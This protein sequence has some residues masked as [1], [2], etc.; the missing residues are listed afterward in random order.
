LN[1]GLDPSGNPLGYYQVIFDR[2]KNGVYYF[3]YADMAGQSQV[4]D[5]VRKDTTVNYLYYSFMFQK[6]QPLEPSKASWDLL[7]TQY[8]TMLFTDEGEPYPY[9]VTGVLSN[10]DGVEV[11]LDTTAD[12]SSVTSSGASEFTYSSALDAIGYDWKT[13]DFDAGSYTVDFNRTYLIRTRE[14]FLYKLRFSG[15]YNSSGDKGYPVIEFREL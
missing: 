14:G 5:S 3:R 9:I 15:F 10:R 2:L 1:A 6:P 7:F 4:S 8:T 13:Y 11:A 12:F